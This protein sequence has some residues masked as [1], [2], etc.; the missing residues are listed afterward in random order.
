[1]T[2]HP[3]F[4]QKSQSVQNQINVDKA[5]QVIIQQSGLAAAPLVPQQIR[6]PPPDFKGREDEI[7]D[8][9]KMFDSGATV[10]G[11][12]GLG[13]VGKTALALVLADRVKDRFPDG[14][15]FLDMQGMSKSPLKPDD[16]MAHIIRS[17]RGADAPLPVDLNGLAGLYHSVLFDKRALI[18]LD[19]AAS[20]EQVEPLLPPAGS[21]LLITSRDKFALA[22]MKEKDLGVLPLE[23]AKKLLLEI[24]GRIGGHAEEL[25]NLCGCLPL[26][27]RNAA[28][29]LK[30]KQNL[31]VST[32][33]KR[34]GD[35]RKRLELVEAS[36]DLSYDLLTPELQRLWSLLSVFPADFDLM[37]VAAVWEM[38]QES[39][40]DRLGELVKWSLVDYLPSAFDEEG[41]YRLHDLARDFADSRLETDARELAQQRHAKHYQELLWKASDLYLQGGDSFSR[42]LALF[43]ADWKNIQ[44]GQKW[45][46]TSAA[47]SFE[48]AEICSNFA[49]TGT[50]LNLR[51]HP[52]RNIEWLDAALVAV[53]KI[54]NQNAEGAHLGNLGSAYSNLGETKKAIEHY[55]QALNISR[56]IGDRKG[57]GNHLFNM[58][59][60]LDKL[61][62]RA[63]AIDLA[64][65]ALEIFEQIESPSAEIV[66]KVL[67]EW[68]S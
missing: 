7:E 29:A 51:L 19:N 46:E 28:Y 67:A 34:L 6:R 52:L 3:N 5:E 54:N 8:I 49:M 11:V 38:D 1:M 27:L 4:D 66:R 43:D 12:R 26:A 16:A 33:I 64:E 23:D 55:E 32:Y 21:A 58:S 56:E 9:I 35:A 48:I 36:F 39:S 10:I 63:K 24:A 50:I 37:G 57:E 42:G 59:L 62:Q 15:L 13:G 68:K 14:Q 40:E 41:R 44:A 31:S 60:S 2:G 17:Y 18:L 53:R 30:E 25:A 47:K 61:D 20:R 65:S 22:D 45:A